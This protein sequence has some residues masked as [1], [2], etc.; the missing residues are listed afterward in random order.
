MHTG[1]QIVR[2]VITLES[3]DRWAVE[4]ICGVK[5]LSKCEVLRASP[6][7]FTLLCLKTGKRAN[8][9]R[10]V[11]FETVEEYRKLYATEKRGKRSVFDA[12]PELDKVL[13]DLMRG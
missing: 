7:D 8:V 12:T 11:F 6:D 5:V 3:E 10:K 13:E 2:Q 1:D 9:A 4:D